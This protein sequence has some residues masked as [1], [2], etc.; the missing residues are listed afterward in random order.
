MRF[1]ALFLSVINAINI[2]CKKILHAHAIS[3]YPAKIFE[4]FFKGKKNITHFNLKINK[5]SSPNNQ[6]STGG[7][8]RRGQMNRNGYLNFSPP[9]DFLINFNFFLKRSFFSHNF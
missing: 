9:L 1:C 5:K 4:L 7:G 2:T 8:H 6:S 3:F